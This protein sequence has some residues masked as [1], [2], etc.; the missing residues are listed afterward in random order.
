MA[1]KA[2][3]ILEEQ[4]GIWMKWE[5]QSKKKKQK[6]N[7]HPQTKIHVLFFFFPKKEPSFTN[8]IAWHS[9]LL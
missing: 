6:N 5:V 8:N 4:E 3:N 2:R 9:G 7:F 1:Q